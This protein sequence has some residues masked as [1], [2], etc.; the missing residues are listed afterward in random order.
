VQA[1]QVVALN[2]ESGLARVRLVQFCGP[3]RSL[4]SPRC[5]VI[6]QAAVA[7]SIR[8]DA[9]L[10]RYGS[11]KT[12]DGPILRPAARSGR[13]VRQSDQSEAV[14]SLRLRPPRFLRPASGGERP[15][16]RCRGRSRAR[17]R[18]A[19]RPYPATGP[20]AEHPD[21]PPTVT[22]GLASVRPGCDA[23]RLPARRARHVVTAARGVHPG[24]IGSR[25]HQVLSTGNPVPGP[26]TCRWGAEEWLRK[27]GGPFSGDGPSALSCPG[28]ARAGPAGGPATRAERTVPARLGWRPATPRTRPR[29]DDQAFYRRTTGYTRP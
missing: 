19:D 13:P 14:A 11:G 12:V 20:F 21:A 28:A 17:R 2:D 29:R 7:A 5:A 9:E 27:A 24:V 3:S 22:T 25:T 16:A 8:H 18:D 6:G 15:A 26:A 23:T 1:R 10:P 4:R